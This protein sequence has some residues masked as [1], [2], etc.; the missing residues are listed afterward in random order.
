MIVDANKLQSRRIGI[1]SWGV[2]Q[3]NK[4]GKETNAKPKPVNPLIR[5][6]TIMINNIQTISISYYLMICDAHQSETLRIGSANYQTARKC[7]AKLQYNI[8]CKWKFIVDS[9]SNYNW[10]N[11]IVSK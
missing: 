10:Y 1:I 8:Q 6:A 7:V 11:T 5:D 3:N 9:V 2:Y 4:G